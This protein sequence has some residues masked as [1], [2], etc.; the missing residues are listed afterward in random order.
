[1]NQSKVFLL[2]RSLLKGKRSAGVAISSHFIKISA[3]AA[4]TKISVTENQL[5]ASDWSRKSAIKSSPFYLV[6]VF[7]QIQE[8]AKPLWRRPSA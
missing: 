6:A 1:M 5:H 3:Q 7:Q 4:Q 2:L 8:D